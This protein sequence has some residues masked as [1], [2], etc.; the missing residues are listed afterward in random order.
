MLVDA[1]WVIGAL[2]IGEIIGF[3]TA[4][5]FRS[6]K[7]ADEEYLGLVKSSD[8]PKYE[9]RTNA[10]EEC[11]NACCYYCTGK[12]NCDWACLCN[13]ENCGLSI[14]KEVIDNA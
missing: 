7:E 10:M 9:C 1:G 8:E 2:V 5:F 14:S 4:A 13:P 12:E 6:A 3:I 11:G